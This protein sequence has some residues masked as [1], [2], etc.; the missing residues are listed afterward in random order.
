MREK[1]K[2]LT[3]AR[4]GTIAASD[5]LINGIL[6]IFSGMLIDYYGPGYTSIASSSFILLGA[7]IRA[8][9][10]SRGSFGM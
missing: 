6:P 8:I 2:G 3:N 9:G 4:Y 1:I 7:I 10:G 5:Q